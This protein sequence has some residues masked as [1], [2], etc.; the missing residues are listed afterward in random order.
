MEYSPIPTAGQLRALG[1][2]MGAPVSYERRIPGGLGGTVDVLTADGEPV[3]LKR[4]WI[5]GPDEQAPAESEYRAMQLASRH[6]V[7]APT[8]LWVDRVGLF[9]E[10]AIVMTYVDGA[11]LLDATDQLAWAGQLAAA[12]VSIHRIQPEPSDETLFPLLDPGVGPHPEE[13]NPEQG[14]GHELG[15][16][17]WAYR[18]E[19]ASAL[20]PQEPTFLHHDFWAG[21][22]LWRD[23]ALIAVIDWEGGCVG[24]PAMDVAYCA[25]DMRLLGLDVAADHLIAEYREL[26]GR[27]LVNLGYW[28]VASL[29]RPLPDVGIWVPSWQAMGFDITEDAVRRRHTAMILDALGR[30]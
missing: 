8:P 27:E 14:E 30:S 12:L 16:E 28:E 6:D 1:E 3:V 19:A 17:L 25:F 15:A 24:D 23:E 21:N 5:T 7:P 13:E 29:C 26:S 22:T 11:P 10:G 20:R 18:S 9:P 4:Y 2:E